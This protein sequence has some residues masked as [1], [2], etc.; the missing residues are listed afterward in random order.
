[1]SGFLCRRRP[2]ENLVPDKDVEDIDDID[3]ID[4]VDDS[5]FYLSS[6]HP[7]QLRLHPL[8][9]SAL[10]LATRATRFPLA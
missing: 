4:G 3:D 2:T 6:W 9:S 5:L 10:P 1:M 8:H 7:L